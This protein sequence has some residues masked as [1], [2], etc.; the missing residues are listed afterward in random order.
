VLAWPLAIAALLSLTAGVALAPDRRHAAGTTGLALAAAALAA[1]GGL[2]LLR[3]ELLGHTTAVGV[4]GEDEVRSA[5]GAAW[6]A[7]AGDLERAFVV[8]GVGGLALW[9]AALL[10]AAPLDRGRVLRGAAELI[11]GGR[12]SAPVRLLRGLVVLVVGAL[13]LLRA[14]PVFAVVSA[15]VGAA[16]LLL[17]LAEALTVA[18]PGRRTASAGRPSGRRRMWLPVAAGALAVTAAL[19]VLLSRDDA[20]DPV[21]PGGITACNGLADL[22]DRRLDE[23]VLPATHN[24]MSAA[25]R[26]GWFFANQT[27]PI[28]RQLADGIRLLMIDP[29]YGIVDRLGRVRTDLTAEGTSRNRVARRLGP[30][31][32]QAAENLA[33]RLGL[34]PADGEREV[35]L[36]H[37]L[38]ELGAEPFGATLDEIRGWLEHNRA[39]V[40][41]VMLESSVSPADVERAFDR[42]DLE[43]YLATL[44]RDG[45]LPT[46][47]EMIASGRRLVVLDEGDGGPA[48]WH[49]PAFVFAQ[50]TSIAV[51]TDDPGS[52]VA[53]RGTPERPLLIMNHWV[54]GFPPSP[55][56]ARAVNRADALRGRVAECVERL[57]R[58]PNVI[59]TDF[60]DEGDVIEVVRDLN[61][62]LTG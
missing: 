48:G 41:V 19:V 28:P 23:V 10:A 2:A 37:T 57:G 4:L 54:D 38:C 1:V 25:A 35:F 7:F 33:G 44:P 61:A 5:T 31:A 8:L 20:T 51:F 29:H 16:L 18:G 62:G 46:L 56:A 11:A 26:P 21:E 15:V 6:D 50:T 60:Y 32:V 55:V 59:A 40:L 42:A 30:D 58:R 43:P 36:C 47:R 14:E 12:L 3:A 34:V 53:G 13:V 45:P 49:Q 52:C 9:A 27:R 24:S 39:E 17:G 22:C